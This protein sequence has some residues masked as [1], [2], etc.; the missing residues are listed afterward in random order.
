MLLKTDILL[1]G[2]YCLGLKFNVI[3][4][5]Q[6]KIQV[7]NNVNDYSANIMWFKK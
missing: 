2:L 3:I 7:Y 5:T 1:S 4:D 6:F